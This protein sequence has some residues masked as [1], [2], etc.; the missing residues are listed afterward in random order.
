MKSPVETQERTPPSGQGNRTKTPANC[1]RGG[2]FCQVGDEQCFAV[3][4]SRP[5]SSSWRSRGMSANTS[6]A[7]FDHFA[8]LEDPRILRSQLHPLPNI[9]FIAVCA[10][11]CASNDFVGMAKFGVSK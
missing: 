9:V 7:F 4:V 8:S 6:L 3:G 1:S 5:P 2:C 11:L 10:V